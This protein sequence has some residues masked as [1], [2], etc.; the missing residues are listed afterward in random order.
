MN[1]NLKKGCEMGPKYLSG[2]SIRKKWGKIYLQIIQTKLIIFLSATT[3]YGMFLVL[4]AMDWTFLTSFNKIRKVRIYDHFF[5]K[6]LPLKVTHLTALI[7]WHKLRKP[8]DLINNNI[9]LV[10]NNSQGGILY[11]ILLHYKVNLS[12]LIKTAFSVIIVILD[13]LV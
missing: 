3:W 8:L 5:T 13:L 4:A 9:K 7:G 10:I 1:S 2:P 6:K 11:L 12:H